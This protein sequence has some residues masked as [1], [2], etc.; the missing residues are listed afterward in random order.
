MV[1]STVFAG[2]N[3]YDSLQYLPKQEDEEVTGC[4]HDSAESLQI[5][6]C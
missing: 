2:R 6:T 5:A 1:P 3:S 4:D